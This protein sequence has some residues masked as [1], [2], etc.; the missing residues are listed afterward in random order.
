[1]QRI[2]EE[3]C[4]EFAH[5]NIPKLLVE[6][7]WTCPELVELSKWKE[8][9][10]IVVPPGSIA[11]DSSYTLERGLLDAVRIRNATTHRHLC[12]NT[13]IKKMAGQAQ[14][15]MSMFG[16]VSRQNRFLRLSDE[17]TE[18]D[19][20]VLD[21]DTKRQKLELALREISERP[22]DDMDW[23]PNS[24]SLQEATPVKHVRL[25]SDEI[26]GGME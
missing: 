19:H 12:N 8:V 17:L 6:N 21:P 10:P 4:Y 2:L 13:E 15:L 20:A 26:M 5:R 11:Q 24:V 23:T 25:D 3:G 1:M 9:L 18:W 7:N 22:V 16:D 14:G